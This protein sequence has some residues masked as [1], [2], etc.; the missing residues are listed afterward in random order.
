MYTSSRIIHIENE[1]SRRFFMLSIKINILGCFL[2]VLL[3]ER[4]SKRI[5]LIKVYT[6]RVNIDKDKSQN[7]FKDSIYVLIFIS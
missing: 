7:L 6:Y 2:S 4:L 1:K 5:T 3:N